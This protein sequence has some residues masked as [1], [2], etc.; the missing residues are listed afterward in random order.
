MFDSAAIEQRGLRDETVSAVHYA[1]KKAIASGCD[2]RVQITTSQVALSVRS[3]CDT[4]AFVQNVLHPSRDGGYVLSVPPT[5]A[6]TGTLDVYFDRIGRPR[7][8]AGALVTTTSTI[9]IGTDAL[10]LHPET[11]FFRVSP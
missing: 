5:A 3:D 6:I 10:E 2:V 7:T 4:G 9:Q 11:G 1:H 8:S